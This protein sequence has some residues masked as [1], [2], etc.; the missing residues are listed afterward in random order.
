MSPK[1]TSPTWGY[2]HEST[3]VYVCVF[4]LL[5]PHLR[6]LH[7]LLL[8]LLFVE[9]LKNHAGVNPRNLNLNCICRVKIAIK[10]KEMQE[11]KSKK[12]KSS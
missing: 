3:R 4:A 10:A 5:L 8:L 11:K 1:K 12:K 9:T 7:L 6:L 2:V